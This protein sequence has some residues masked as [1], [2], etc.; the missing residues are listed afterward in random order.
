MPYFCYL[1]VVD[2]LVS[3]QNTFLSSAN[4]MGRAELPIASVTASALLAD[5]SDQFADI[6]A[7]YVVTAEEAAMWTEGRPYMLDRILR[8]VCARVQVCGVRGL[9]R[10]IVPV[11]CPGDASCVEA[12]PGD[13]GEVKLQPRLRIQAQ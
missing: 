13:D 6:V 12:L 5:I 8:K 4:L 9:P 2:F 10:M 3:I 7:M 1:Q 11:G